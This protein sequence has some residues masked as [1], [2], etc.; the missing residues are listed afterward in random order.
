MESSNKSKPTIE[1]LEKRGEELRRDITKS[2]FWQP[3]TSLKQ[4]LELWNHTGST[5]H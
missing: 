1:E 3:L 5:P 2:V 4:L